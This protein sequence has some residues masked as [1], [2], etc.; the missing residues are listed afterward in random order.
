MTVRTVQRVF[1]P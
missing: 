1:A